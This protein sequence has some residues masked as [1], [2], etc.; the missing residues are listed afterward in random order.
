MSYGKRWDTIRKCIIE[1][2]DTNSWDHE[3]KWAYKYRHDQYIEAEK[4]AKKVKIEQEKLKEDQEEKLQK[5]KNEIKQLDNKN[6]PEIYR[7]PFNSYKINVKKNLI[8]KLI[9]F[10]YGID[11]KN[12]RSDGSEIRNQEKKRYDNL[13]G[14][15]A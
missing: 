3:K 14:K 1:N 5:D 15:L 10:C 4:Q 11:V 9:D 8:K 6:V 2:W 12:K 13:Q 7:I